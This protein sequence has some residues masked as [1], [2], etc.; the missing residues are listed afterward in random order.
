MFLDDI[1]DQVIGIDEV[2]R[3]A[4]C[5]PVVSCSILLS[6]EIIKSDLVF[7]IND[8]KKIPEKKRNLIAEFIKKNSTYSIGLATNKEIDEINILQA[9]NLS[10]IRSFKKFKDQ[11][12]MVK[13]DGTKTFELNRR[14]VFIKRGDSISVSI[15]AASIIAK[16]WRDNLM[17]KYSRIHPL[18][19]WDKNKGYGTKNHKEAIIKHG[20]TDIH[21][22][23]FLKSILGCG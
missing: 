5:G 14:T 1:K 20:T 22:L 19:G 23:T 8:S 7:Q 11:N 17:L 6:R 18:Y 3:G 2:G 15:A 10:M 9:T 12:F 16:N 4:L 21:R 13:I